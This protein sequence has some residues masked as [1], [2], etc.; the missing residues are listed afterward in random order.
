MRPGEY[1]PLKWK[2]VDFKRQ[3][4]TIERHMILALETSSG[5]AGTRVISCKRADCFSKHWYD[6]RATKVFITSD[7][8]HVPK[9][10]TNSFSHAVAFF[11]ADSNSILPYRANR[12]LGRY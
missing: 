7:N 8:N 2:S 1:V 4:I 12:S 10:F 11:A 3:E 6:V 5:K 9:N